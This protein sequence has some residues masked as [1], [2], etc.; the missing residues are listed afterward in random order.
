MSTP[1]SRLSHLT[2]SL[3][4]PPDLPSALSAL[5]LAFPYSQLS[6]DPKELTR[7]GTSFGSFSPAL[8]PSIIVH[9]E[10]TAD[11]VK[12]VNIATLYSIV[13]IPVAGRTSLEGQFLPPA[14]LSNLNTP[15]PCCP[16]SPSPLPLSSSPKIDVKSHPQTSP[17][18]TRPTIHLSLSRMDK[19]LSVHPLDFQAIVQPGV[20]W[21]T[22]NEHLV[23]TGVQQ[24]FPIDPAP[25]AQFGGMVGVGGSGTNAVGYGTMRSEWIQNLE[26]VLMSGEVIQTRGNGRSRKTSTG[27]DVGLALTSFRTVSSA[28]SFVVS[29]LASG[30]SPISLEMLDGTSI[31]GLNLAEILPYKLVE[32]PTVFITDVCVPISRLAEFVDRSE[33]DVLAS[34]LLAPIVAHIGD[35][36]VHRAILF[37]PT[38]GATTIPPAVL[39]LASRLSNLA[40]SLE[41]TCAGEHGI[42]TTKR[43][44]LRKELGAGTLG[45]MRRVKG[46]L[47]PRGLLNPGKVLFETLEEEERESE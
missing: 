24:Q 42:G 1:Q 10:S 47:D 16:S 17:P 19:I 4:P 45:V 14:L 9:A 43:K 25:G 12:V 46:L 15:P 29:L 32:E 44:F 39:S 33:L 23:E 22:L 8:P 36:N 21:Q 35:G 26:V 31:R 40:I 41:G 6:L 5:A 11:V 20:G 2:S 28:T 37:L 27:W 18:T 13:V 7:H 38:P 30:V 34:G 3:Q